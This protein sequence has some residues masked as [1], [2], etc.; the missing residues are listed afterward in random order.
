MQQYTPITQDMKLQDS[1]QPIINNNLTALSC[2][3][4]AAFPTTNLFKGMLCFRSDQ[5]KLYELTDDTNQVWTLV[6]DLSKTPATMDDFNR[7]RNL[8]INGRFDYNQ[9]G[10]APNG[11]SFPNA[12]GFIWDHWYMNS[13][14]GSGRCNPNVGAIPLGVIPGDPVNAA[15]FQQTVAAASAPFFMQP[16]ESVRTLAGRPAALS[17]WAK[18]DAGTLSVSPML[19]QKFGT[20][21]TPSADVDNNFNAV[22]VT[23]N[24]QQ[25][26]VQVAIPSI[27]GKTI[28]TNGDDYLGCYFMLPANATFNLS[29][30]NVQLEEN[31]WTPFEA[32]PIQIEENLIRRYSNRTPNSAND[33]YTLIRWSTAAAFGGARLDIPF[34][35]RMRKAPTVTLWDLGGGNGS[36]KVNGSSQ[37]IASGG[38]LTT[39]ATDT[40]L[41]VWNGT[42]LVNVG[43]YAQFSLNLDAEYTNIP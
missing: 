31:T 27:A 26:K 34:P 33:P 19:R 35:V 41:S 38:G 39:S 8:L 13:G 40:T 43:D 28:G 32:R 30:A 9:N 29:L 37:K 3:E 25:F 20:G 23:T 7:H 1:M 16:V 2:S 4:G 36:V 14:S 21:G 12:G 24:W 42:T 17:F 5:N 18:V 15:V 10:L 22:T 6:A 11:T